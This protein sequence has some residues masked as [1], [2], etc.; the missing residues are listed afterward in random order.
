ML[1]WPPLW[2][3]L[4]TTTPTISLGEGGWIGTIWQQSQELG[5]PKSPKVLPA[6]TTAPT[7]VD[8]SLKTDKE[9]N[10]KVPPC[11]MLLLGSRM[12]NSWGRGSIYTPKQDN[13]TKSCR[14]DEHR[15]LCRRSASRTQHTG[16]IGGYQE[17]K[18]SH[19][20]QSWPHC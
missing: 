5:K 9:G 2:L 11:A 1:A 13:S 4:T 3:G 7:E 15:G 14:K 20:G 17:P 18:S 10:A 8:T 16:A 19:Y 12:E 6:Q